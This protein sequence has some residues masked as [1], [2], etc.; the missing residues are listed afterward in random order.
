M[1]REL[2]SVRLPVLADTRLLAPGG[3]EVLP[4]RGTTT[5]VAHEHEGGLLVRVRDGFDGAWQGR[6]G[7]PVLRCGAVVV[8]LLPA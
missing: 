4:F 2:P 3:W 6:A 5:V 8:W 7:H 1:S